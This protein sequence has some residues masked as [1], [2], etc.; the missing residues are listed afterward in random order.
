MALIRDQEKM[1][2]LKKNILELGIKDA[3]VQIAKTVLNYIG[4]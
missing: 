1:E 3:D 4:K 2:K